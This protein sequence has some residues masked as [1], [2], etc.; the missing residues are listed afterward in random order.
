MPDTRVQPAQAVGPPRR[1]TAGRFPLRPLLCVG[2]LV[3]IGSTLLH[4]RQQELEAWH[5]IGLLHVDIDAQRRAT[6][7]LQEQIQ[8]ATRPQLLNRRLQGVQGPF[9]PVARDGTPARHAW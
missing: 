7:D 5:R 3:L 4:L 1:R 8:T 6:W 2:G 9:E